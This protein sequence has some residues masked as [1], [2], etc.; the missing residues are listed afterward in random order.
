MWTRTPI[1][2]LGSETKFVISNLRIEPVLRW[3]E[4][5]CLPDPSFPLGVISSIYYDTRDW[6]FMRE[7][8][9]SDYLK[10]KIRLRWYGSTAESSAEGLAFAEVKC[11]IG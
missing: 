4:H 10:T 1:E 3:L 8:I 2:D 11:R 6:D 7:K 9:N 5:T